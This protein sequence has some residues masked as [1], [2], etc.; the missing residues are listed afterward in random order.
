MTP[1]ERERWG[2]MLI[3]AIAGLSVALLA[4]FLLHLYV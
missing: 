4:L 3:S 1:E 2:A